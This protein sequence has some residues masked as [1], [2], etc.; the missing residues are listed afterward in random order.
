MYKTFIKE[1]FNLKYI[2]PTGGTHVTISHLEFLYAWQK[3][4]EQFLGFAKISA[5][6]ALAF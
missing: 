2:F 5:P 1:Q 6:F 4:K 3:K